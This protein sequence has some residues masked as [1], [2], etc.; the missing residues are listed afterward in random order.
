MLVDAEYVQEDVR[1]D[2][3]PQIVLLTKSA[4]RNRNAMRGTNVVLEVANQTQNI[5]V[6]VVRVARIDQH[7]RPSGSFSEHLF[8]RRSIE[9][10]DLIG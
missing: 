9:E 6:D 5:R 4:Q 10:A 1:V 7:V 8:Q 2:F 3:V